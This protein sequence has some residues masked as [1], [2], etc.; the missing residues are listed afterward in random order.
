MAELK[1]FIGEEELGYLFDLLNS[2]VVSVSAE[3]SSVDFLPLA[4]DQNSFTTDKIIVRDCYRHLSPHIEHLVA[5]GKC[6][7][8]V[9]GTPGIG[10]TVYG[11]LLA[12]QYTRMGKSVLYWEGDNIFLFSMKPKMVERFGLRKLEVEEKN[13]GAH[14][15]GY[16][17]YGSVALCP[18]FRELYCQKEVLVIHDPQENFVNFAKDAAT[19]KTVIYILPYGHALIDAWKT[20]GGFP[21][22]TF[23]L[24]TWTEEEAMVGGKLL[25]LKEGLDVMFYNFGGCF[26]AW[27]NPA[28]LE[29]FKEK[30]KATVKNGGDDLLHRSTDKFRGSIVHMRVDFEATR[31]I[32]QGPGDDEIMKEDAVQTD[33]KSTCEPN[34]FQTYEFVFGSQ[35]I[36]EFVDQAL[37]QAGDEA[38]RLCMSTWSCQSGYE[39]IYGGLFELR[40]H[41]KL[42]GEKINLQ[43]RRVY[44][45]YN[46]K[47]ANLA[48]ETFSITF[49]KTKHV[50][51]YKSNDPTI[52][53]AESQYQ[54][55]LCSDNYFWPTSS[56]H[57]TY[58]S[59]TLINGEA[60][61]MK[62]A[63]VVALLLQMTVSG[64]MG[65]PR[66]P[67]HRVMQH[68]RSMFDTTFEGG[69]KDY[70]KG[71]AI[72]TFVVP[73]ECF[74]AFQF[75][76]E[77]LKDDENAVAKQQP[78]F[79]IVIEMP[80]VF[81]V[82]RQMKDYLAL[83]D[84]D[85]EHNKRR[86][87]YD[88]SL[89]SSAKKFKGDHVKEDMVA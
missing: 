80:D 11:A 4:T 37:V 24:P 16:W 57:P 34:S 85:G 81:T 79:Q 30:A 36:I 48:D 71:S 55:M 12:R 60:V 54:N 66:R 62:E 31:P 6:K 65:L 29:G 53:L 10:K 70:K 78:A 61:G 50:V 7:V 9:T 43:A 39:S 44:Y 89:R 2:D 75:Q 32:R 45:S 47:F 41:R 88:K 74:R 35:K 40:C 46:A 82:T 5:S 68:V 21:E 19:V 3:D 15:Y 1:A 8:A 18:S 22:S 28:M 76:Y 77:T 86:H 17:K 38:L 63:K 64:S 23:Y 52:L 51:R 59:A 27:R 13:T 69:I 67:T 58:D 83:P 20:K 25:G 87:R 84:V 33:G 49:P 26:R 14:F 42:T 56:N 73:P 72:T